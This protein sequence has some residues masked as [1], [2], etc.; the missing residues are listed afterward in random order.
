M[1]FVYTATISCRQGCEDA[2]TGQTS[3]TYTSITTVTQD[4]YDLSALTEDSAELTERVLGSA[5]QYLE[6]EDIGL[7]EVFDEAEV[8]FTESVNSNLGSACT[9]SM[10][11][12]VSNVALPPRSAQVVRD[13]GSFGAMCP[14][15]SYLTLS[16]A[17]R[18]GFLRCLCDPNVSEST[19]QCSTQSGQQGV[20][21]PN[22][23]DV[24]YDEETREFIQVVLDSP[25]V[26]FSDFDLQDL[27]SSMTAWVDRNVYSL[28]S[29]RI[30]VLEVI[31]VGDD[32]AIR[33]DLSNRFGS[34]LDSM[35]EI[36]DALDDNAVPI[37]KALVQVETS[38]TRSQPIS[39]SAS[40][41]PAPSRIPIPV[42]QPE[43]ETVVIVVDNQ[44]SSSSTLAIWTSFLVLLS[45]LMI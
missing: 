2:R 20:C 17:D 12:A 34:D 28:G 32:T 26:S 39:R 13:S 27:V 36:A 9:A 23:C 37:Q 38:F 31:A 6:N 14:V 30:R 5:I 22:H 44:N 16:N 35:R 45:V 3:E 25:Y 15:D 29:M 11:R 24:G 8:L 10:T 33:F 18:A 42:P 41:A 4:V 19:N 1:S 40:P 43:T 21:H 7:V